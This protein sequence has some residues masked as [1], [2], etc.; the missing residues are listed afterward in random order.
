MFN[1]IRRNIKCYFGLYAISDLQI[2]GNCGC[3]G[4]WMPSIILPKIWSWGLCNDCI[5]TGSDTGCK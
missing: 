3:C 5:N 1:W 4:K 2:G